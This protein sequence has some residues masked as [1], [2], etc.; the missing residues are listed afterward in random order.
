LGTETVLRGPP[1]LA[2]PARFGVVRDLGRAI[3]VLAERFRVFAEAQERA[4]E[5]REAAQRMR[6][7]LF[8]SVS[9]DLKSPLNAI[10]G[11][12][13]L[14]G[15]EPLSPAQK[16][17]LALIETRG[18]EL[19]ALIETILDA[20]R[21][22]VGQLTLL[23]RPTDPS[24]IV[25][26]AIRKAYDLASDTEGE[27]V[28]SIEPDLPAIPVDPLHVTRSIAVVIAHALRAGASPNGKPVWVRADRA[29]EGADAPVRVDVEHASAAVTVQEIEGLFAR[30]STSRA[31]GL[32]LGL[33]LARSVIELHG[34][35]VSVRAGADGAP[36]ITVTLSLALPRLP[37]RHPST[38]RS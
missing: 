33:S 8:A 15:R 34:G 20:A 4:I 22:E 23:P 16:E 30:R 18:R 1:E 35:S 9:H 28:A 32:T 3:E 25:R 17:S 2:R 14:V 6:G 21:V 29:A 27:A 37:P 7:L 10:L 38:R 11:F 31:R 12:A 24:I 5:A 36:I 26:E 19:L 13:E